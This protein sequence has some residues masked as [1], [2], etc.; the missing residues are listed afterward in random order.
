MSGIELLNGPRTTQ[1]CRV[2]RKRRRRRRRRRRRKEEEAPTKCIH[3]DLLHVSLKLVGG[4][5]I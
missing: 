3:D 4:V 1:G 2:N 5:R